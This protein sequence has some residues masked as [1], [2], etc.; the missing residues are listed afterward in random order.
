MAERHVGDA[1][2]LKA[3]LNLQNKVVV[4]EHWEIL[5]VDKVVNCWLS[6]V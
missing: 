2:A 4:P 3:T 6:D 1:E 5:A